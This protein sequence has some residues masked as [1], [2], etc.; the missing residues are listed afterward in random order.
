MGPLSA[1]FVK[2]FKVLGTTVGV[3]K[4]QYRFLF[5]FGGLRLWLF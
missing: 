1:W 2:C 3:L 5:P 4:I